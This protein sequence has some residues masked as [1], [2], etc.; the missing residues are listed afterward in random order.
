MNAIQK[1]WTWFNG[2]P[3]WAR[4]LLF[5]P[6]AVATIC[7]VGWIILRVRW[8]GN[9]IGGGLPGGSGGSSGLA[10]GLGKLEE[11]QQQS[12]GRIESAEAA[13]SAIESGLSRI[14]SGQLDA[15]GIIESAEH[16]LDR[17]DGLLGIT[18]KP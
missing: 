8:I 3:F 14:E 13:S 12:A 17:I 6:F 18:K 4:L 16:R 5:I 2:L 11:N 10:T 9:I 7:A 15:S 1:I